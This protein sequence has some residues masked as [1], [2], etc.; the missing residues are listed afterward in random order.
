MSTWFEGIE[1]PDDLAVLRGVSAHSPMALTHVPK[2][3]WQ[4]GTRVG[5]YLSPNHPLGTGNMATTLLF[6]NVVPA[7]TYPPLVKT[8]ANSRSNG[9]SPRKWTPLIVDA[10]RS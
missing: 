2:V 4:D 9:T 8:F 3:H 6:C 1:V 5:G 10:K 7:N